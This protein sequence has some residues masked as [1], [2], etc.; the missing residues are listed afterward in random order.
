MPWAT[1]MADFDFGDVIGAA[2]LITFGYKKT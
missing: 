1:H 2:E